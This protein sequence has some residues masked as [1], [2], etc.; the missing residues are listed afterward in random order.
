MLA[1]PQ[2]EAAV[3]LGLDFTAPRKY[4]RMLDI[5]APQTVPQQR[6]EVS[7]V[8]AAEDRPLFRLAP[9]PQGS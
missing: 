6:I 9:P 5:S 8:E 1:G 2:I 7:S 3:H 4:P